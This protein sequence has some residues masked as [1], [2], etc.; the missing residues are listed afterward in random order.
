MKSELEK[1]NKLYKSKSPLTRLFNTG[2]KEK[3]EES[4][5]YK[6]RKSVLISQQNNNLLVKSMNFT[7]RRN[8]LY[9]NKKRQNNAVTLSQN[10][11]SI[12]K[13]LLK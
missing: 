7:N 2:N 12:I 3:S 13:N 4:K 6:K 11:D 5:N 9:R 1:E 10:F 8:Y